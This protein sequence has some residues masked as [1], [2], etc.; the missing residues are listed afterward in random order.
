[1]VS[2][3]RFKNFKLFR[4]WQTLEIKPITILIGKNNT[5]KTAVLK[6]PTMIA[7]CLNRN[8]WSKLELEN[9]S[10]RIE[11]SY[12]GLFY[13]RE[14]NAE[15]LVFEVYAK[16]EKIIE[17]TYIGEINGNIKLK[18][19]IYKGQEVNLNRKNGIKQ[20]DMPQL[21]FDYIEIY[22]N[23]PDYTIRKPYKK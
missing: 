15:P 16:D 8:D 19:Y 2:I 5:G 21:N 20:K 17:T 11:Y 1:M 9:Q 22:R 4:D 7:G 18:K 23:K 12:E 6:L 3:I 14:L 13:N 10:V